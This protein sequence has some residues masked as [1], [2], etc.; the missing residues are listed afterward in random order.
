MNILIISAYKLA[1]RLLNPYR[2]DLLSAALKSCGLD[3]QPG[4][5]S[6]D[7]AVEPVLICDLSEV[8][9]YHLAS[10]KPKLQI[11]LDMFD[12]DYLIWVENDMAYK[13]GR[14]CGVVYMGVWWNAEDAWCPKEVVG[15]VEAGTW[16]GY[17]QDIYGIMTPA[18]YD[19][20]LQTYRAK[21]QSM[22][23]GTPEYFDRVYAE[24]RQCRY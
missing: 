17:G 1:S 12:Q 23:F 19:K 4:Q 3:P 11:L 7:S 16:T 13:M 21:D 20:P 10:L 9:P 6:V 14:E 5:G 22:V 24:R 8:D 2:Q 18:M 15:A